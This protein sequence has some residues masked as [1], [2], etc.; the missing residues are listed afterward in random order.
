MGFRAPVVSINEPVAARRVSE[1][2]GY[3]RQIRHEAWRAEEG[4]T[5]PSEA[6]GRMASIAIGALKGVR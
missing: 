3:L 6:I 1:L 5:T 4:L 2:E